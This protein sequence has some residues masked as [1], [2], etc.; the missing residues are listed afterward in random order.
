[1]NERKPSENRLQPDH[2]RILLLNL[3]KLSHTVVWAFFAGSI[4]V[5]PF[6]GL[7]RRFG[8][9][10]VL[11]AIVLVECLILMANRGCCPLTGL[12]AQFTEDRGD[13]FDIFLPLWL[14][15]HNKTIFGFLFL[16]GELMVLSCWLKR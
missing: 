11:T 1:M 15:R 9:A 16:C 4:V 7:K 10:L 14:A 13:N 2:R 3:I 6:A 12:A 8:W 5:L